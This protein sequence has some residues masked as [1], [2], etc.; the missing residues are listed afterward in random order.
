MIR[1]NAA[2]DIINPPGQVVNFEKPLVKEMDDY[3]NKDKSK[4]EPTPSLTTQP[5]ED[6]Q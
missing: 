6:D 5:Q 3:L 4:Q 2:H 1:K